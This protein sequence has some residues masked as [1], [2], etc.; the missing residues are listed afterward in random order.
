[1]VYVLQFKYGP[2]CGSVGVDVIGSRGKLNLTLCSIKAS[3]SSDS[4]QDQYSNQHCSHLATLACER[5][6]ASI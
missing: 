3:L 2:F 1:M 5:M 4:L 6:T